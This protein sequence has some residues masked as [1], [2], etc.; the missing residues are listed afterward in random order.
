MKTLS[1][2]YL[3]HYPQTTSRLLKP[4]FI[5]DNSRTTLPVSSSI[6]T[7]FEMAPQHNNNSLTRRLL[8][9]RRCPGRNGLGIIVVGSI[10]GTPLP[11]EVELK[12]LDVISPEQCNIETR[13]AIQ[14]RLDNAIP[15]WRWV[16]EPIRKLQKP[17]RTH[18]YRRAWTRLRKRPIVSD[19]NFVI[20]VEREM[21]DSVDGVFE[22]SFSQ[23]SLEERLQQTRQK[24]TWRRSKTLRTKLWKSPSKH[25]TH[26]ASSSGQ[27]SPF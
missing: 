26:S 27:Q 24:T 9:L 12:Y 19:E 6:A 10:L 23:L 13:E 16:S 14:D 7:L 8:T 25:S 3:I 1:S 17:S 21:L 15:R 4:D 22:G 2:F 18:F 11:S 5:L 20:M